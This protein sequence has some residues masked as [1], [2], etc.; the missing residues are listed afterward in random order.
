MR[1]S[2][3]MFPVNPVIERTKWLTLSVIDIAINN[4]QNVLLLW[5]ALL[6]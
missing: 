2:K 3:R 1:K 5:N 6:K 4:G